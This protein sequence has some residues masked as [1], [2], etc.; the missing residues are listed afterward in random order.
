M[1]TGLPPALRAEMSCS[2]RAGAASLT[3]AMCWGHHWRWGRCGT[4]G[5]S[6]LPLC[7]PLLQGHSSHPGAKLVLQQHIKALALLFV[8]LLTGAGRPDMG[9]YVAATAQEQD[10]PPSPLGNGSEGG[11]SAY[12]SCGSCWR[13][14]PASPLLCKGRGLKSVCPLPPHKSLPVSFGGGRGPSCGQ[15]QPDGPRMDGGHLPWVQL[16]CMQRG[17]RRRRTTKSLSRAAG[18]DISGC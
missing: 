1:S 18:D 13:R 15:L 3:R 16:W 10:C 11:P 12:M 17:R 6:L 5:P 9:T 8:L 7:H 4:A 14:C 2:W